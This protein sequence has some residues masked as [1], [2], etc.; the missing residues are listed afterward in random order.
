MTDVTHHQTSER[1]A[2]Q[3]ASSWRPLA[4]ATQDRAGIEYGRVLAINVAPSFLAL[5][6]RHRLERSGASEQKGNSSGRRAVVVDRK[7]VPSHRQRNH[8]QCSSRSSP[9]SA[10]GNEDRF[11]RLP[12]AG[13]LGPQ[14]RRKATTLRNNGF[15]VAACRMRIRFGVHRHAINTHRHGSR[16]DD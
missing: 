11:H 12:L 3:L 8:G 2:T 14:H 1:E 6:H 10:E 9:R 13:I 15:S 7:T 16:S 5:M 4:Q